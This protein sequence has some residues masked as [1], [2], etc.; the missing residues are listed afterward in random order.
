MERER[1]GRGIG[2]EKGKESL[3]T[4]TLTHKKTEKQT[5]VET[6]GMLSSWGIHPSIQLSAVFPLKMLVNRNGVGGLVQ[7]KVQEQKLEDELKS[8][9]LKTCSHAFGN[10]SCQARLFFFFSELQPRATFLRGPFTPRRETASIKSAE[11][12][13]ITRPAS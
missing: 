10:A 8:A 12:C 3:I 7:Y 1:K 9:E 6:R 5:Q 4:E 11:G 13:L 2:G